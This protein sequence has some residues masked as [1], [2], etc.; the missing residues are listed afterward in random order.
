MNS[1]GGARSGMTDVH[2]RREKDNKSVCAEERLCE[3]TA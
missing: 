1:Q 3:D 2:I